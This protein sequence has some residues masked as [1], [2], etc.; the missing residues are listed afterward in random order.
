MGRYLCY[1]CHSKDFKTNNALEPE[2]SAGYLGGGN[3][4][5][6]A[7]GQPIRS[8]NIT[9]DPATGLGHW[10]PAQLA[11]ALRTGQSPHGPVRYPMPK[12]LAMTDEEVQGLY[13]YLQSVPKLKSAALAA[14]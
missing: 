14:R 5:L 4:L 8:A 1:E 2:K 6:D 10:T 7:E 9:A 12:Y 13:A 3:L 11:A